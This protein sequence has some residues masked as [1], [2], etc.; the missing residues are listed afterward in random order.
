MLQAPGVGGLYSA[1]SIPCLAPT[2][3]LKLT[4][5]GVCSASPALFRCSFPIV[6]STEQKGLQ[7]GGCQACLCT[8]GVHSVGELGCTLLKNLRQRPGIKDVGFQKKMGSA[9]ASL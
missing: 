5:D 3:F 4:M 8:C 6:L 1:P 7:E 2:S 9:S